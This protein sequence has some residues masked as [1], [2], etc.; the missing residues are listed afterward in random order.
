MKRPGDVANGEI[1]N[2]ALRS[3]R[4]FVSFTHKHASYSP[5]NDIDGQPIIGRL[6]REA[7]EA[8]LQ[9]YNRPHVQFIMVA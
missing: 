2:L 8:E 1:D 7:A 9:Y 3:H 6:F 5:V 4:R